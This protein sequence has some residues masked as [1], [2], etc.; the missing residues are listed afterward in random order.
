MKDD[1]MVGKFPVHLLLNIATDG[2]EYSAQ[3]GYWG[4]IEHYHWHEWYGKNE[5]GSVDFDT[6]SPDLTPDTVL[7]KLRDI[8]GIDEAYQFINIHT[9]EVTAI[10]HRVDEGGKI[11][12]C[13][14]RYSRDSWDYFCPEAIPQTVCETCAGWVSFTLTDIAGALSWALEEYAH[15]FS[16][17]VSQGKITDVD[18]DAIGADVVIQKIVLGQVIYG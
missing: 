13:G 4:Q 18:Y 15:L 17:T 3:R 14:L 12:L 2:I 8:E 16:Y 6:I 11:T 1:A 5:N 10:E 9:P 7:A